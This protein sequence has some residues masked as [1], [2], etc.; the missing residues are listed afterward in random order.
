MSPIAGNGTE[1][2]SGAPV[3]SGLFSAAATASGSGAVSPRPAAAAGQ[4]RAPAP[5]GEPVS[6]KEV[7]HQGCPA[8]EGGGGGAAQQLVALPHCPR[9]AVPT[10]AAGR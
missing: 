5:L 3:A 9:S 7:L 8:G 6:M 1:G 10:L 2:T 4:M